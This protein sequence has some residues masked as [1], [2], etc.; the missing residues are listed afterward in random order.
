M[1]Q[2]VRFIKFQKKT[3]LSLLILVT[4]SYIIEAQESDFI[5]SKLINSVNKTPISFATIIIKNKSKGL[6]SNIDGGFII[7][8]ELQKL[9]DTLVI[10][11][12][13]YS[14]KVIPLSKLDKNYI[15]LITLVEKIELLNEVIVVGSKKKKRK[16][17]A[18]KIVKLALD[19]IPDNYP[20]EPFSYVGYYRDYQIK[21]GKYINLNEALMEIFDSGFSYNDITETQ[22]RI[23]QYK[24]NPVFPSDSIA[25]KPYDYINRGKIISTNVNMNNPD[26]NEYI[27]LRVHD[28]IR[29]YNINSYDFVNRFNL[30]FVKNHKLKLLSNTFINDIPLY[31]IEIF[32]NIE[33]IRVAG[34]IFISKNNFEIYKMQYAVYDNKKAIKPEKNTKLLKKKKK[35]PGKLLY[36]IIIEYRLYNGI[37]Y[38]NYISFNNSFEVLQPPKFFLNEAKVNS[39]KSIELTFNNIPVLK[40]ALKKSNYNLWYKNEKLKI[41]SIEVKKNIA[42]LY[43]NKELYNSKT[44]NLSSNFVG[45][46][47]KIKLEKIKDVYG[48]VI[49]QQEYESYN[50]FREFFVQELRVN[51][52]KPLDTLYM[53]NNEPIF[54]NQPIAPFKNI[55]DY[56]LNTPLKN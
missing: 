3:L 9:N 47:I 23:Y 46:N 22:T 53:L 54:K 6:I 44:K 8:Y 17:S 19:K 49:H 56:W 55:S 51:S 48:N 24:K 31:S 35:V 21:G 33:N 39:L 18:S 28:A 14:T 30:N 20:F 50:Q 34:K 11:S 27:I 25:T 10:S 7:P 16:R 41:D 2:K 13:G 26:G 40:S 1:E 42:L 43:L 5:F 15:N 32:K 45:N 38:P 4:Q 37:M 12:I 36:E 29:N 52:K